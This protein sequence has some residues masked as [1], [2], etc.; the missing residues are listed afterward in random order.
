MLMLSMQD[1]NKA[2]ILNYNWNIFWVASRGSIGT[3]G[4][5]FVLNMISL[6]T[7][8]LLNC[9][10][11]EDLFILALKTRTPGNDREA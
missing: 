2:T 4:V 10:I 7:S 11:H 1:W 8:P 9:R 5:S 6:E 3:H